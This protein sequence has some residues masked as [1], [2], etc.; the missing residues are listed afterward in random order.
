[1]PP[2]NN[3]DLSPRTPLE[4]RIWTSLEKMLE[5]DHVYGNGGQDTIN[6]L[7]TYISRPKPP[8]RVYETMS[9]YYDFRYE[10]GGMG[11]VLIHFFLLRTCSDVMPTDQRMQ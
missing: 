4:E 8:S 3:K 11:Y 6:A 7:V 5:C 1:M 9:D 10:D 2:H